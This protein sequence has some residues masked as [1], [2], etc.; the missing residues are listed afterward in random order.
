V[1]G[2]TA[3]AVRHRTMRKGGTESEPNKPD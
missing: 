3:L 1:I 2:F